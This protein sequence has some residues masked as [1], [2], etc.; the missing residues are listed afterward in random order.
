MM[1]ASFSSS[2]ARRRIGSTRGSCACASSRSWRTDS[3]P[4]YTCRMPA[5]R[6][7]SMM[8]A[9]RTTSSARVS[10]SSSMPRS[11]SIRRSRMRS[12]R[13]RSRVG[14]S[15]ATS[16]VSTPKR[17]RSS[18]RLG[19]D[20]LRRRGPARCAARTSA[21]S[22]T[23]GLGAAARP[24]RD[25]QARARLGAVVVERP[26]DQVPGD[27]QRVEIGS[28]AAGGVV[29][30]AA[31]GAGRRCRRRA[32]ARREPSGRPGARAARARLRR[33]RRSRPPRRRAPRRP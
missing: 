22:R 8:S 25:G 12:Q 14:Y 13:A 21:A 2:I 33:A 1:P 16:R 5:A 31:A 9:S 3:T 26:V 19:D 23:A 15:S 27:R 30:D 10:T 6:Y 29:D 32:R 17:S 7:L 24:A 28:K 11:S 20:R 4:T 18:A